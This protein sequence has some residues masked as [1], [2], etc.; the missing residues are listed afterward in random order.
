MSP[1]E[2]APPGRDAWTLPSWPQQPRELS[3]TLTRKGRG[4]ASPLG[5][6]GPA[7]C[8]APLEMGVRSHFTLLLPNEVGMTALVPQ[9]RELRP[10]SCPSVCAL[11]SGVFPPRC[12]ALEE[13]AFEAEREA[14]LAFA[15]A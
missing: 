13:E 11:H 5:Q 9:V 6:P 2:T 10:L 15:L 14:G 4:G 3:G 1:W 7:A 8:W 12:G